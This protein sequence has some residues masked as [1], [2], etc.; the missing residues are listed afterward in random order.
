MTDD[1][2]GLLQQV[3]TPEQLRQLLDTPGV[4]DEVI[5][6]FAHEVGVDAVLDRVFDLMGTRF[7]PDK[8]G[9]ERGVITWRIDTPDGRRIYHLTIGAGTAQGG[10][11]PGTGP[12]TTLTLSLPNMLRLC[13]GR[14]NAV[15]AVMTGKIKIS[16]DLMFGAKLPG[17]F[18][19]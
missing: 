18:D 3:A 8:A 6:Q 4:T 11:G 7:L 15:T 12:R 2:S 14:L 10:R 1:L 17:M 19:Y 13:A 16:G 9:D 5:Q